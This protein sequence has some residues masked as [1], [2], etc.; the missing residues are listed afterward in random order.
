[1]GAYAPSVTGTA[2][3]RWRE[4]LAAWAIPDDLVAAAGR[5]P[6]GHPVARFAARADHDLAAPGGASFEQARDG[7][8]AAA[9]SG[10]PATVL[11][12]GAGAG[13]ASLP[14]A[15]WATG[16]TAVDPSG[17]MLSA[18]QERAERVVPAVRWRTVQGRWPDA[19]DEA[20]E[21]DVVV[22][23]HVVYDVPDI[24]PFLA[25]LT[26]VARSRVVLEMPPEH[27][28]T[29][30]APLWRRFHGTQRPDRPTV[31]DLVAV[32]HESGVRSLT[33]E[34]W[35]RAEH[36]TMSRQD[37]VALITRRLCLPPS[38]E[39]EVAAALVTSPPPSMRRL[40][41]LAWPGAA[42]GEPPP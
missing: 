24:A 35:V 28:L 30:M 4:G 17:E 39:Q 29:W 20:G 33:V 23:H 9:T 18:F 40:V 41:T 8:T 21:H 2:A 16:V 6:W 34:R 13:A 10:R 31:D 38:R 3:E 15:P 25:A 7:L 19:A 27:P 14:L 1:V 5:S 26:A 37:R 42:T 36:D 11:D 12:V 32:L 22:C